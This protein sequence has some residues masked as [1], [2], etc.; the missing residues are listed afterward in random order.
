MN[1]RSR[2]LPQSIA[3]ALF[4]LFCFRINVNAQ[5]AQLGWD[6]DTSQVAGYKVHYGP[7]TR[8]YTT[9]LDAKNNTTYTLQNMSG[10]S[11]FMTYDLVITGLAGVH[12]GRGDSSLSGFV[13]SFHLVWT[14][15]SLAIVWL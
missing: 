3:I 1:T 15:V 9:T 6:P 10:T 5:Q 11:Y 8:D 13:P 4:L 14:G 7:S 12:L 2:Y